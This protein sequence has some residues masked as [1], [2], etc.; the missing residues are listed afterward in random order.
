MAIDRWVRVAF[1]R[2]DDR[3]L[4]AHAVAFD[5]TVEV[6][7]GSLEPGS[8]GGWMGY[9]AG[10]A[11]A[12]DEAGVELS[13]VDCLIDGDVPIG[14]GVSSSAALEMAAG[15]A[16]WAAAEAP[17]DD[18]L[19]PGDL[20]RLGQ[21]A[22]NRFVGVASGRMDQLASACGEAG[23]ALLLDCRSFTLTPVPLPPGACVVVMDTGVRR[24]LSGSAYND[25]RSSCERVVAA[26]RELAPE[27]TALRDADLGLLDAARE[28]L[29]ER[30]YRRAR[31]VLEES[32]R[33]AAMSA[34]LAEGAL[35]EAGRLMND[36]HESLRDLYEVSSP[37]LDGISELARGQPGCFGAR[38]TGAGFGGCA[39]ALVASERADDLVAAVRRGYEATFG[40]PAALFVAEAV[41]GAR[42]E[43]PR[44]S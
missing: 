12:L 43:D 24:T 10:I 32:E 11:W 25:R 27:V 19:S 9:V 40:R 39:V 31:H 36:S 8:V 44:W 21:R 20:A 29:E 35:V 18:R 42:L 37:E 5:E 28:R 33:P 23:C 30:D 1:R 26:L 41:A 17:W 34:A 38:L 13:G 3:R 16:L 4:R 14:A 6:E 2:R 7:I 22:E 15:R